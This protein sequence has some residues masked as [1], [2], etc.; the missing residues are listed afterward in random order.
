MR[1]RLLAAADAYH[2]MSEERPHR[3]ALTRATPRR[4]LLDDVDAG[5][6]ARAEVDAVLAAAG[7]L[8]R[9]P[10]VARP[11]G[12]T[13]REVDVLRLIARAWPTRR[14]R[15][16]WGSHPRRS[17]T[18]S[19]TSTPR[20]GSPPGPGR[21]CSPWSTACCPPDDRRRWG[22]RPMRTGVA[23]RHSSTGTAARRPTMPTIDVNDTTLYFE[24]GGEGPA[25]LFV[26][27]MCGDAEVW[28]DQARRFE[29]RYTCVRYDRRG[30]TRSARG[31]ATDQRCAA[32]RRRRR[33]HRSPRARAVPAGGVERRGRDRASRSPCATGTCCAGPCSAN[34]RCSAST[35]RPARPS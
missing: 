13:E 25:I 26:H 34:R 5:R 29:D 30:H 7:Q 6:F 11:A 28:A 31:D 16:G 24:R 33:P 14:W 1:A 8:G 35:A 18:T 4:S 19:S 9:P 21:R 32:R 3:P 12:L 27:G 2:A 20:P 22:E 17:D 23:G 15:R 10:Q